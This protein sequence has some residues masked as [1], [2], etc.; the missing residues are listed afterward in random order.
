MM[1]NH[2]LEHRRRI[3]ENIQKSYSNSDELIEKGKKAEVGEVRIWSGEKWIRHQDGWVHISKKGTATLER[4]GGKRERAENH[5]I[6]HYKKYSED[7]DIKVQKQPEG[8]IDHKNNKINKQNVEEILKEVMTNP[9]NTYRDLRIKTKQKDGET[10]FTLVF[11]DGVGAGAG[12]SVIGRDKY[13][14]SYYGRE[15]IEKL[16]KKYDIERDGNYIKLIP[17]PTIEK[18]NNLLSKIPKSNSAVTFQGTE[19]DHKNKI[20]TFFVKV[21]RMARHS[22][23]YSS[24]SKI[25]EESNKWHQ[26]L[27]NEVQSKLEKLGYSYKQHAK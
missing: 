26:E 6:E 2:I 11:R 17:N 18:V 19:V 14:D 25:V 8:E 4:P 20:V 23:D 13:E 21:D 3:A 27:Y 15:I 9:G 12:Q 7:S 5:H 24:S 16:E 10:L 22:D 1:N